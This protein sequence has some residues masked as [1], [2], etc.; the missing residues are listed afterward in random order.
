MHGIAQE[1]AEEYDIPS[2]MTEIRIFDTVLIGSVM[3]LKPSEAYGH[4][5]EYCEEEIDRHIQ[6]SILDKKPEKPVINIIEVSN[7]NFVM[8]EHAVDN[9]FEIKDLDIN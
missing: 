6:A 1:D 4:P 8:R 5:D 9:N 7:N 2:H 3:L